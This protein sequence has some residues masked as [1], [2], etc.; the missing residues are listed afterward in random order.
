M[1]Q[2]QDYIDSELEWSEA[3]PSHW[4]LHRNKY[5]FRE[6]NERTDT[7]D[8]TLLSLT[9]QRG[10]VDRSEVTDREAMAATLEG[11]KICRRGDL[12]M[13][14]MQAWNGMFGFAENKG[15]VSP[16]YSVYRPSTHINSR[17]YEYLF[18]AN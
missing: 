9:K 18:N 11:Y 2:Y 12:V 4:E 14:R 7:G 13:N 3:I 8:E 6:V 10:L 1:I 5:L 17:Y 16:D 15:L